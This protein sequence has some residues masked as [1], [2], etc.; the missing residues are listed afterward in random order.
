GIEEDDADFIG[1]LQGF[2]PIK[3][4]KNELRKRVSDILT[5]D[6]YAEYS[7]AKYFK[8]RVTGGLTKTKTRTDV[9]DNTQ[10]PRGSPLTNTGK[11][12]GVS[13]SVTYNELSSWLNEN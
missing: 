8:L 9:F 4:A 2:N 11:D 3:T 13:G 10:T 5:T 6:A 1:A 12:N 7:F